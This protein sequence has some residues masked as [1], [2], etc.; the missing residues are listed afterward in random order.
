M[1]D[2]KDA[3]EKMGFENVRTVL[4]SGNVVFESGQKDTTALTRAL[5]SGLKEAFH[6]EINVILRSMDD[7]KKLRASEPFRGITVTPGVQIYVTFLSEKSG[8]RTVTIPYTSPQKEFSLLHATP[9]E[10][11]SVLDL[12]KGKGTTD[13]MNILKKEYGADITTRNWNTVLKVLK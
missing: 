1:A 7:L 11:F 2:L 13:V 4:A 10:V 6:R 5:E 8:P 3:F 9:R 12:S